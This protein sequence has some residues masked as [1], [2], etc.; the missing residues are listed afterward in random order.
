M[1]PRSNRVI[2]MPD[3]LTNEEDFSSKLIMLW[4]NEEAWRLDM[5]LFDQDIKLYDEKV[6]KGEEPVE[7]WET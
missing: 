7:E 3:A 6:Q 4:A 2:P 5:D 1:H